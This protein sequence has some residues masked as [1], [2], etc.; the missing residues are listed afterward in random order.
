MS[1]SDVRDHD[2]IPTRLRKQ[3]A[4]DAIRIAVHAHQEM[5]EENVSQEEARDDFEDGE[6]V[7]NVFLA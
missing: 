1:N 6:G 4:V 3:T 7:R 2:M 5:A